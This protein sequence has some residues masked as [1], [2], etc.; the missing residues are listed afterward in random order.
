MQVFNDF[1]YTTVT[2]TVDQQIALFNAA[3]R[4]AIQL[5]SARNI[6]DYMD[7]AFYK[8]F[9]TQSRRRDAYASGAVAAQDLSQESHVSVKVA[10]ANGPF[11]FNP[12]QFTWIQKN[13]E[14][15]A[16]AIGEQVSQAIIQDMLN[17]SVGACNAAIVN[18][19][20]LSYDGSAGTMDIGDLNLGAA[21]FG[22]KAQD[23]VSWVMHSKPYHD[24][25]GAA[26]TN[27]NELFSFGTI[28]VVQD[29]FGRPLIVSDIP[30]LFNATP[31]PDQY[32]TL[33]LVSGGIMVEDNGD[34]FSNAET[35]NGDENIERTWQSEYT[36][37]VKLKGYSWDKA[38]GGASPTDAELFTGTNWDQVAT[39]NKDT[40]GVV[41]ITQ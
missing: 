17:A 18:Q 25:I 19:G 28:N 3:S 23:I 22:D 32:N 9:S 4:G 29:G 1:I 20:S 16:I 35:N 11:A 5:S 31:T 33:G 6:G 40:A 15:A 38:N 26:I 27:T 7:A 39:Y 14:E 30:A 10:G 12:S 34:F 2:E 36:F 21:K 37:N 13:P 41:V 24:L 8:A